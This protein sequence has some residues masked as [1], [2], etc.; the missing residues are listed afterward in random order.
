[1][2]SEGKRYIL[3]DLLVIGKCSVCGSYN[4]FCSFVVIEM[5]VFYLWISVNL[6]YIKD[7]I[8]KL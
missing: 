8:F 7:I 3:N 5:C 1:M 4:Y 6:L 2:A